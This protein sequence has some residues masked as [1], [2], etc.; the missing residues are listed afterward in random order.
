MEE[1]ERKRKL[2][3]G[4]SGAIS[5][6]SNSEGRREEKEREMKQNRLRRKRA[7]GKEGSDERDEEVRRSGHY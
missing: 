2:S 7:E 1:R 3:S 4:R 5:G 6:R